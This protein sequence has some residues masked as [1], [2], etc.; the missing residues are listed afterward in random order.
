[1][2]VLKRAHSPSW[3]IESVNFASPRRCPVLLFTSRCGDALMFS[4]PPAAT[5]S[6]SPSWIIC[7]PAMTAAM[8]DAHALLNVMAEVV[9][10]MPADIAACR[11]GVCPNPAESMLPITT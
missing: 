10:G 9:S 3:T 5:V 4:I 6:A 11:A 1:M 8:P 7:E 2:P